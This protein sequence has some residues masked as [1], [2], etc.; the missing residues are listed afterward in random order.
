M[1]K[2]WGRANSVN[3]QKV[4]WA[5]EELGLAYER[6]DAGMRFGV[7]DTPGYR[8]LNPNALVPTIDDDG[9]VLWESNAIVRY[10]A[11]KYGAGRNS[12][13]P[14]DIRVRASADR[15]MD[16]QQTTLWTQG[17]R[18]LFWSLV[19]TPPEQRDAAANEAARIRIAAHLKVAEDALAT[20][21]YLC[22]DALTMADIPFGCSIHRWFGIEIE[23]PASPMLE[24]YYRRL[25]GRPGYRR[26]VL[27]PLS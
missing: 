18:D 16:W 14:E 24:A 26:I 13:W 22:G 23:R 3:V 7:V 21:A 5:C 1:L 8:K 19:R 12:L 27:Q 2:I 6:V 11:Q 10:L 17:L 20:R 9:F 25:A 4:L 15:W